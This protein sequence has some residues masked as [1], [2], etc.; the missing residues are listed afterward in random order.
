MRTGYNADMMGRKKKM[1]TKKEKQSK[2]HPGNLAGNR[3][4]EKD[5][6]RNDTQQKK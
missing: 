3:H 6:N 1:C 4:S 2:R 5:E